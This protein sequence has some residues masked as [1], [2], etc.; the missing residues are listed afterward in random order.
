MK[1]HTKTQSHTRTT[2]R[3][4]TFLAWRSLTRGNIGTSVMTVVM[5][6]LIFIN[7][8]FLTSIINGLTAT[9]FKQIIETLTGEILV[10]APAGELFI[11]HAGAAERELRLID[12]VTHVSPRINVSVELEHDGEMGSY[13]GVAVDPS[14]EASVTTVEDHLIAGRF[15]RSDDTNAIILGVQIAGG[16]N[17]E[18]FAYSLKNVQ[19]EDVVEMKFTNGMSKEYEV[20]GIF[21]SDFVQADNRFF[22]TQTEYFSLFP[23]QRRVASEFAVRIAVDAP[24]EATAAAI[25]DTGIT[26]NV[27]TWKETA[28]LV[29]SFT[30]S[31]DVVNFI[32][33]VL[34]LIVA[35]VT[36]F[37][38][39]YVD[40]VNRRR[41]IGI[42]R[43]I[44]IVESS[45]AISYLLRALL[46][47]SVGVVLGM[48]LFQF[49]I[50]PVFVRRPLHLP[51]GNV[52]LVVDATTMYVRAFALLLVSFLGAYIPVQKTLR[53]HIINAIWGE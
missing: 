38:V 29:E 25:T 45:I 2:W 53:M 49:A 17:V 7:L 30:K 26:D 52:S 44:G 16:E 43:A 15:L 41:Q 37:I 11:D 10:E 13:R 19:V 5:M 28:G 48:L 47:A 36:I 32:V 24:L 18:L 42:L 6:A 9:A 31:F 33:S 12:G 39:M 22:L 35:G 3:V 8:I 34:A 46:Y 14:K 1:S 50:M 4:G 27:R 20:V 23:Q 21:D 40:V 51:V